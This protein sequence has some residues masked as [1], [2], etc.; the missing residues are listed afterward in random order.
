MPVAKK[1]K[2]PPVKQG[3][4]G[5]YVNAKEHHAVRI[6]AGPAHGGQHPVHESGLLELAR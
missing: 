2:T 6:G 5:I 3:K 4:F 1:T